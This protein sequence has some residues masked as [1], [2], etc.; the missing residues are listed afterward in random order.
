[1]VLGVVDDDDDCEAD[2]VDDVDVDPE[3]EDIDVVV[4]EE[5]RLDEPDLDELRVIL[6]DSDSEVENEGL[7]DSIADSDGKPVAD[8]GTG[9]DGEIVGVIECD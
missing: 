1:M 7:L 8:S 4:G 9:V 5:D 2:R 3:D 6:R